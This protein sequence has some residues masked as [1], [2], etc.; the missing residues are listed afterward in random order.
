M[1]YF[2]CPMLDKI[3]VLFAMLCF[4]LALV[5]IGEI[6]IWVLIYLYMV[7][8]LTVSMKLG[9]DDF[10]SSFSYVIFDENVECVK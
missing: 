4:T 9:L 1:M 5:I 3:F 10:I 7:V 8:C 6:L 2:M